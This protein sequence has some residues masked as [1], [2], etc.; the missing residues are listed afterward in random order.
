MTEIFKGAF[1]LAMGY[2]FLICLILVYIGM[3]R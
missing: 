1:G 3:K 2:G